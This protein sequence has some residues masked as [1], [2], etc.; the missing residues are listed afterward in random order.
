[1][2]SNS[3][4]LRPYNPV[5]RPNKANTCPETQTAHYARSTITSARRKRDSLSLCTLSQ[6]NRVGCEVLLCWIW[7]DSNYL[8]I[9]LKCYG[10]CLSMSLNKRGEDAQMLSEE[11]YG[12]CQ[13]RSGPRTSV[14]LSLTTFSHIVNKISSLY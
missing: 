7:R 9:K 12:G 13:V 4:L 1:M 5:L 3:P 11:P 2:S 14:S 6:T 8:Q 10:N